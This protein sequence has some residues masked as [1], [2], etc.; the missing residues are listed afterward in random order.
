MVGQKYTHKFSQDFESSP[1]DG[2]TFFSCFHIVEKK[3]KEGDTRSFNELFKIVRTNLQKTNFSSENVKSNSDYHNC[4]SLME[5]Y[6]EI[7]S[8][9]KRG[10]IS[11]MFNIVAAI[12]TGNRGGNIE[13]RLALGHEIYK[14]YP[15]LKEYNEEIHHSFGD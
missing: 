1:I 12:E 11:K 4:P 8:Y 14:K 6:R 7:E 9:A 10:Q 3:L 2:E 15:D 5:A 13:Q